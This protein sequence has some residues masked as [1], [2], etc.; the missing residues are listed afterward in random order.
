MIKPENQN[1]PIWL[2]DRPGE[3]FWIEEIGLSDKGGAFALG[4]WTTPE[5]LEDTRRGQFF[6]TL[7]ISPFSYRAEEESLAKVIKLGDTRL[8]IVDDWGSP[9]VIETDSEIV[10]ALVEEAKKYQLL[11]D[12]VLC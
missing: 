2:S 9:C 5:D 1:I 6:T 8:K 3:D 7:P 11:Q 10:A 12:E 4:L